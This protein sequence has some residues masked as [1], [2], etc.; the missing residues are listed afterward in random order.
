MTMVA[1]KYAQNDSFF[2]R[3]IKRITK[4]DP[5]ERFKLKE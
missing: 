2:E 4:E 5:K 1:E 3:Q